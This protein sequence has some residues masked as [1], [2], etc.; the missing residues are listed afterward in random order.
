MEKIKKVKQTKMEQISVSVANGTK[1]RLEELAN[2]FNLSNSKLIEFL[3]NEIKEDQL[4]KIYLEHL[5][6][7]I[8][9]LKENENTTAENK[10]VSLS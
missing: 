10:N 3:L 6:N 2:L 4:K 5:Q 9:S 7:K 1:N 8:N